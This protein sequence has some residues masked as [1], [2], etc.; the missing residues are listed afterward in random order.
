MW[1]LQGALVSRNHKV[2]VK[3]SDALS[4]FEEMFTSFQSA[5]VSSAE[6]R[7]DARNAKTAMARQAAKNSK[8]PKHTAFI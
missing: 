3:H 5:S 2:I 7:K 4:S 1:I 8:G 6:Q